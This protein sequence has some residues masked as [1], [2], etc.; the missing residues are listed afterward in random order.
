MGNTESVQ[1]CKNSIEQDH[2]LLDQGVTLSSS[3]TPVSR[4]DFP[5]SPTEEA[6]EVE[7][8]AEGALKLGGTTR[9]TGMV[10][11][12]KE[13]SESCFRFPLS[14]RTET[15]EV[16][17]RPESGLKL[18]GMPEGSN[19][20]A[21]MSEGRILKASTEVPN[22]TLTERVRFEGVSNGWVLPLCGK[23]N[24]L[25]MF[26]KSPTLLPE[27]IRKALISKPG[28]QILIFI[29][30][31]VPMAQ[32]VGSFTNG[33]LNKSLKKV[34]EACVGIDELAREA[35]ASL[36]EKEQSRISF[37][38]WEELLVQEELYDEWYQFIMNNQECRQV[39]KDTAL[40]IAKYRVD[41]FTKKGLKCMRFFDETGNLRTES[42][43]VMRRYLWT[44]ESIARE[45]VTLIWGFRVKPEL[46]RESVFCAKDY[47]FSSILYMTPNSTGMD[48]ISGGADQC[49]KIM[50]VQ[51]LRNDLPPRGALHYYDLTM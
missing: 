9:M 18:E 4:F 51:N 3:F 43:K 29:A 25:K 36:T 20:N 11:R 15:E 31:G 48:L 10:E 38:T 21:E 46:N 42:G 34:T 13:T 24:L 5:L 30:N 28:E 19:N 32:Q 50:E 26:Q 40:A 37:V 2:L 14:P 45:I 41:S 17:R 23:P 1:A 22:F 6:E 39:I 16:E 7:G 12:F 35:V 44:Q 8:N 49:R 27:Y 47:F 33:S